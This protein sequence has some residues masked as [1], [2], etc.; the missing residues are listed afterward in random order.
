MTG[1]F[2]MT[3]TPESLMIEQKNRTIR[4]KT[5]EAGKTSDHATHVD[6]S[7]TGT[8]DAGQASLGIESTRAPD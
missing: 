6:S 5:R 3:P 8:R 4:K 7:R 2:D 1:D